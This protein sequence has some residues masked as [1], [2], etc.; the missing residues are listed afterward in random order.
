MAQQVRSPS[1]MR[2]WSS[3]EALACL[4]RDLGSS[5]GLEILQKSL[6]SLK[7]EV[8][9]DVRAVHR[10]PRLVYSP[11]R[12]VYSPGGLFTRLF[13]LFTSLRASASVLRTSD[14]PCDVSV[15]PLF[16]VL[17]L[18]VGG[19]ELRSPGHKSGAL[20]SRAWVRLYN[21]SALFCSR[22]AGGL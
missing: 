19:F 4:A 15:G 10:P 7:I 8:R 3:E 20:P 6:K 5:P 22:R 21:M 14:L 13:G 1:R 16:V 17:V 2:Q 12:L 18:A 11:P 9:G